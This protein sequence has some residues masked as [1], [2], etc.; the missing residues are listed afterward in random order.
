VDERL[1]GRG[2]GRELLA[3]AEQ[4]AVRH[5]CR[6]AHLDTMSFQALPFYLKQGY[7]VFGELHDWP[8]GHARYFLQ[9]SLGK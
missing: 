9:K 6:A 3:A 4:E 8:P 5:G 7:T 2:Y 1:R